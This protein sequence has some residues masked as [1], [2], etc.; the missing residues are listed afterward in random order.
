MTT[1]EKIVFGLYVAVA[2]TTVAQATVEI[3]RNAK[4]SRRERKNLE[5]IL[6]AEK[7]N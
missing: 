2:V 7:K 3:T 1:K 4:Q 5:A 6:E